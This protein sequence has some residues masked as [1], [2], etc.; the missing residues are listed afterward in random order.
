M[1][2]RIAMKNGV[3]YAYVGNVHDPEADSTYCHSCGTRLI[4]RDWY[5]LTAW[6]LA[7]GGRCPKCGTVCAGVF[8]DRPGTWGARYQ[9]VP[10]KDLAARTLL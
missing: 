6:D 2:R 9:R 8:E 7:S 10:M 5:Q 3:R 4:G 1:A